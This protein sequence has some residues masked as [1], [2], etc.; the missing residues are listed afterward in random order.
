MTERALTLRRRKWALTLPGRHVAGPVTAAVD[1]E[2]SM[3][4]QGFNYGGSFQTKVFLLYGLIYD[5]N[6]SDTPG[7]TLHLRRRGVALTLG[8]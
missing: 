6:D 2:D 4:L 5:L 8:G 7:S 3:L 1:V